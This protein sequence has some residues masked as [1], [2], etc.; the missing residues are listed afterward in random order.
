MCAGEPSR[1]CL[2]VHTHLATSSKH[3]ERKNATRYPRARSRAHLGARQLHGDDKI[4][5][6]LATP[7]AQIAVS[8]TPTAANVRAGAGQPFSAAVT[9]TTNQ[10]V[11]WS[12]NGVVGGNATV[13]LITNAGL[14]TAPTIL[15]N[16]NTITVSATS[17]GGF[18]REWRQ[19]RDTVE[20]DSCAQ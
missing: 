10:S 7:P 18:Q 13:G 12:V 19:R 11:T 3:L 20:R 4:E 2:A 5:R 15:T 6:R 16:P 9:G 1:G 17:A 8:V 14:Y